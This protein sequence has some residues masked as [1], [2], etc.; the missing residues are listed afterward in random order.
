MDRQT[1]TEEKE[2]GTEGQGDRERGIVTR[3]RTS[4]VTGTE[5]Y[6]QRPAHGRTERDRN[7][8]TGTGTE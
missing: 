8:G 7:R 5:G 3:T 2:L 1:G 6:G 4:R